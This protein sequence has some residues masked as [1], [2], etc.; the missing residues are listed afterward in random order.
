M[1]IVEAH[2]LL[3]DLFICERK[4]Q[5]PCYMLSDPTIIVHPCIN[6]FLTF[7]PDEFLTPYSK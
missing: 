4:G 1:Q 2:I 7:L 3:E 5:M 6:I